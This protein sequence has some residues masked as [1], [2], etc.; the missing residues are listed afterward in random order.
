[1][2]QWLTWSQTAPEPTL[3]WRDR[4]FHEQ[5]MSGWLGSIEQGLD[6]T[7][8]VSIQPANCFALLS[9]LLSF[10]PTMRSTSE[11]QR[12]LIE[13]MAPDLLGRPVNPYDP[14][15]IRF[16]AR[17]VREGYRIQNASS[18]GS[19]L[20][21]TASR[22]ARMMSNAGADESPAATPSHS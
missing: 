8:Y 2:T 21:N 20:R 17:V 3:D 15:P 9:E 11:H 16:L 14:R 7:P 22:V 10:E 4:Y 6:C 18:V 13:R 19:Y 5:R 12:L 1:M